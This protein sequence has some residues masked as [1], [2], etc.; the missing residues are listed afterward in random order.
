MAQ[1]T[2]QEIPTACERTDSA[3][4]WVLWPC[5]AMPS[6]QIKALPFA[7]LPIRYLYVPGNLEHN[8]IKWLFQILVT[9][10]NVFFLIL[11][12]R[13]LFYL[14]HRL[15]WLLLIKEIHS[16]RLFCFFV[17]K[18]NAL[19]IS[20]RLCKINRNRLLQNWEMP[21]VVILIT[22][23][24]L[25][26][27]R[28]KGI[29]LTRIVWLVSSMARLFSQ[30]FWR[31][32]YELLFFNRWD[33]FDFFFR[34]WLFD[35]FSLLLSP[36]A[37]SAHHIL[38][39]R[40]NSRFNLRLDQPGLAKKMEFETLTE[41]YLKWLTRNLSHIPHLFSLM[42]VA[43]RSALASCHD[44]VPKNDLTLFNEAVRFVYMG[45]SSKKRTLH[46]NF[47]LY[48]SKRICL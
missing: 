23:A 16:E 18:I 26:I 30:F 35:L 2:K 13:C 37:P 7:H 32:L 45:F 43:I 4:L 14:C 12:K 6:F 22:V 46:R 25:E 44:L 11:F 24:R 9:V 28:S 47:S 20:I 19:T 3:R 34:S 48:P 1:S 42:N 29:N 33:H 41:N 15:L 40:R 21:I 31:H 38:L 10:F 39:C 27:I 17:V 8:K 5:E 36:R